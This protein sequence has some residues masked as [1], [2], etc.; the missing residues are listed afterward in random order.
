VSRCLSVCRYPD[1]TPEHSPDCGA[2][3][4]Y[5][6]GRGHHPVIASPGMRSSV[7]P[8]IWLMQLPRIELVPSLSSFTARG[9]SRPFSMPT[10]T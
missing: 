9:I 3:S 10:V 8:A 1:A 6:P 4:N 2:A 5:A 7:K